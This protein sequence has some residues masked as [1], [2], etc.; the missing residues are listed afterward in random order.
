M[1]KREKTNYPVRQLGNTTAAETTEEAVKRTGEVQ[2][3]EIEIENKTEESEN[4]ADLY[5][6][7]HNTHQTDG[8]TILYTLK[9]KKLNQE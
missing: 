7:C 4:V 5:Q 3:T 8:E 6:N 9:R 2:E 1:K